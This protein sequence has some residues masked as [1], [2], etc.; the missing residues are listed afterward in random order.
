MLLAVITAINNRMVMMKE[1]TNGTEVLR[2]S[3][4]Y[5]FA[6]GSVDYRKIGRTGALSQ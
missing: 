5:K 6:G 2:E 4:N 1:T 3:V